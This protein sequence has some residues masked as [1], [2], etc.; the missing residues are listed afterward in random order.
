MDKV[1]TLLVAC[2]ATPR[3][4]T[5]ASKGTTM[6]RDVLRMGDPRLLRAVA[7]SRR[8]RHAGA[9]GAARRH[10][11]HDA[12][13]ERRGPRR[14]ADR[15]AAARRHLRR[16]AQSALSRCRAGALHRARQPGAD[17][18]S[19]EMEDGWE[20]CLSVPGL[21][22]VVPRYAQLRYAGFD[23]QGQPIEREV[24][25]LP[26]ARRPARM[27]PPRRHPVSDAHPRLQRA[28]ASPTCCFPSLPTLRTIDRVERAPQAML[29]AR[30]RWRCCCCRRRRQRRAA[31]LTVGPNASDRDDCARR[32]GSRAT[33]TSSRLRPA[34]IAATSPYGGRNG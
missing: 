18:L 13:A 28:S 7:R 6:I 2:V 12:R 26:R 5:D 10:A 30:M 24:E 31:T 17:P 1:R 16:R 8:L 34:P 33:T 32:R 23:P 4:G 22:G 3:V 20:G 11:R 27:R 25:R 19:D 15:R 9:R 14:A 29:R 21:R